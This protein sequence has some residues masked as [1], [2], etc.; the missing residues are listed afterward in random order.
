MIDIDLTAQRNTVLLRRTATVALAT[1]AMVLSGCKRHD[2]NVV[3]SVNGH[4]ILR[5][6]LDKSYE[7]QEKQKQ[8]QSAETQEEADSNRVAILRGM[9]DAEIV[10]QRAAQ[11]KL[12]ATDDEVDAKLAEVKARF[13]TEQF[14]QWLQQTNQTTDDLRSNLRRSITIDR[15]LNKEIN[16]KI[17]VTDAEV[18]SYYNTHKGELQS[19]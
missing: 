1:I 10:W 17:T 3:A 16:S 9:I 8:G 12:T 19:D 11:M 18:S 14:N 13:T 2:A 6:E 5:S 4:P 15:L 7:T